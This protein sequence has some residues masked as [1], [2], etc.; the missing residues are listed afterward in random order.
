M[1]FGGGHPYIVLQME[2]IEIFLKAAGK[3]GVP[4]AS[5]F[6]TADLYDGKNMAMVVSTLLVLGTEVRLMSSVT[7]RL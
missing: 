2:N 5:L 6:P 7:L 4:E 3:Y 1:F